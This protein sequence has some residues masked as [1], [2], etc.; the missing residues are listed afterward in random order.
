MIT[1]SR[2]QKAMYL[3]AGVAGLTLV[4][5][6]CGGGTGSG[7][8]QPL[9][10]TAWTLTALGGSDLLAEPP[11]NLVFGNQ[12]ET[13]NGDTFGSTSCNT[14]TG[15]YQ[16]EG[17][18]ISMGPFAMTLAACTVTALQTQETLYLAALGDAATYAVTDGVLDLADSQGEVIASFTEFVAAIAGSSWE[19]LAINNGTGGVQSV[20]AGTEVTAAFDEGIGF[21]GSGG[22]NTF[23]SAYRVG[24]DYDVING[25]TI[26]FGSLTSTK[27]ACP[28]EILDQEQ[29]YFTALGSSSIWVLRGLTLEFRDAGGALQV[30]FTRSIDG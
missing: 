7:A 12:D 19:A 16:T 20:L 10:Q 4:L 13:G 2:I 26:E 27:K 5:A 6:A 28:Q 11:T 17:D 3:T 21:T 29:R 18:T 1:R 9:G 8:G 25:G 14:F 22:C 15:P 24:E 30:Q 23:A